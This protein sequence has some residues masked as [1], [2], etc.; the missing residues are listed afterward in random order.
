MKNKAEKINDN[1]DAENKKIKK[2]LGKVLKRIILVVSVVLVVI[3]LVLIPSTKNGIFFESPQGEIEKVHS[4]KLMEIKKQDLQEYLTLNGNIQANNSISVYPQISGK[5]SKTYVTL[6]DF[7]RKNDKIAEIDPSVP[8]SIYSASPVIASIS[9]TIT[10]LPLAIGT[11]VNSTTVIAKIGNI[12][13]LQILANVAER[14]VAVLKSGLKA[15]ISLIAYEGEVFSAKVIRVSPVLDETSRSKEI[16]L[17]FDKNDPRINAGMYAKIKL[18]TT[19]HKNVIAVPFTSVSTV[20]GKYYV[21]V[22]KQDNT[23]ERRSVTLGVNV[24]GIT[25]VVSGLDAGEK[26][27]VTGIQA[28]EE[29]SRIR[30]VDAPVDVDVPVDEESQNSQV[31]KKNDYELNDTDS[32]TVIVKDKKVKPVKKNIKENTKE[33][34]K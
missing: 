15:E 3:I 29:G 2:P 27:I 9:G 18:F 4:V 34:K 11:A 26:I 30:D 8:G 22:P 17:A 23:V 1:K 19:A 14:D 33:N 10:S 32:P 31:A 13:D 21:F 20:D 12:S 6:G 7:V 24:D 5:I 25:E 16:Y 28:L